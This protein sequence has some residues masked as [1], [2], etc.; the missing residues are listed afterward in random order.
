MAGCWKLGSGGQRGT[1]ARC[2]APYLCWVTD[3][4]SKRPRT[5][6]PAILLL[7]DSA[8]VRELLCV[9]LEAGCYSVPKVPD[10][11]AG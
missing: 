8:S 10:M 5:D 11:M 4:P 1:A 2:A 6:M 7:D 3:G 9:G